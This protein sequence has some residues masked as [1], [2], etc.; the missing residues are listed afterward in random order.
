[1]FEFNLAQTSSQAEWYTLYTKPFAEQQVSEALRV[2]GFEVF[3][4]TL[5]VW[6]ARR[7][8][9]EREPLF[10][11]YCFV[12]LDWDHVGLSNVNWLPGLRWIV[13]TEGQPIPIPE[14]IIYHLRD[15]SHEANGTATR[16]FT[17]GE[18]V[19]VLE[20]PYQ[21]LDAVFVEP[22][23]GQERAAILIQT[24]GRLIR[25]ELAMDWLG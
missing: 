2:R 7:R 11:C 25:C 17:P 22:L 13:Q 8:Q 16:R 1:M 24:L 10:P 6:R 9:Y 12:R 21:D 23:S 20:G 14:D 18:Q 15:R 5:T 3:L 4:P 19:R